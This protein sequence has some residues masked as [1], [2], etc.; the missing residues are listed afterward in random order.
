MM[1]GQIG[2]RTML[3]GLGALAAAPARAAEPALRYGVLTDMNGV[4]SDGTG[5]GSV[6]AARIAIEEL[7]STVLGGAIDLVVADHQNKPDIGAAIARDWYDRGGVDVIL[8]VPVSSIAIAIANI[9]H[10]KNKMFITSG[11]GSAELSGKYCSP[12]FIQWTY[13]TYALANVAGKAMI[14]RGGDTWFFIVA[15]YVFGQQL[16][17]DATAVVQKAGGK[18]VG[19]APHPIGTTDFSAALL[20]AKA[21]GAKVIALANSGQD[22]QTAIKQAAEFGMMGGDQKFVALLIDVADIQAVG[23]PVAHGLLATAGFYWNRDD[24]TRNLAS[25]FAAKMGGKMPGMIQAGV[26]SSALEYTRAVAKAGSKDPATVLKVLRGMDIE[27]DFARHGRL[28]ADNLMTHDMYLA[29][30]KTPQQSTNPRDVYTILGTVSGEDAA[31]PLATSV[32]PMLK[33]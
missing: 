3:A 9:A 20:Q 19:R 5:P 25:R 23:L 6:A 4:F 15:D 18:V 28:R 24:G 13:T 33:S 12:N 30:V 11:A 7:G 27:D 22:A 16:E 14:E 21:S 31:P 26:Y 32:C 17:R 8:D 29:E 10:E 2:R 1:T